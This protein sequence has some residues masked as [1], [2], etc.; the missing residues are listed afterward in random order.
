M[1]TDLEIK[2]HPKPFPKGKAF[3]KVLPFREYVF[4]GLG[5]AFL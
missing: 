4:G 1:I 3:N 5:R 2:A